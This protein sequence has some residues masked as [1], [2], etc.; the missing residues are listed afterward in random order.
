MID[1]EF[2]FEDM[3]EEEEDEEFWGNYSDDWGE[4]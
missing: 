1:D 2:D 3:D 4:L